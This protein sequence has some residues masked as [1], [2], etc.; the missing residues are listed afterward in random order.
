[1]PA[2][3]EY[4][5]RIRIEPFDS[6]RHERESFSC[7]VDRLDNFFR[8]TA[9]KYVKD[10]N[11]KIYVAVEEN[12]GR[13]VGFHAINPHAIDVS[14]FDE[15]TRKR[16]PGGRDRISAFYLSMFAR[17]L[18][19]RGKG[20]APVLLA[21][22]FKRCLAAA[23]IAGGRFIVLDALDERAEQL[24]ASM[25]FHAL[26]SQPQ[27]MVISIAKVRKSAEAAARRP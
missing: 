14:E 22:V 2:D 15:K 21:D 10:D 18:S 3:L 20:L 6:G 27:R 23:D 1:M 8:I 17:D 19:V 24:Y 5:A 25:G 7:G 26:P 11:G 13:V 9:S 4:L 16:F 12:T